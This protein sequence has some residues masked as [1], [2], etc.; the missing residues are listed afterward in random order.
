MNDAI[1]M[2]SW[3]T[4][5]DGVFFISITTII[6]GFLGLSVRYCLKSKCEHF[7]LC[8]GLIK[9]DR[10]VDLEVQEEMRALEMGVNDTDQPTQQQPINQQPTQPTN[11][12]Q[13]PRPKRR[14]SNNE[15]DELENIQIGDDI[16]IHWT[17]SGEELVTKFICYGKQGLE[18]D[19]NDE[20]INYNP[21]DDK[22]VLCFMVDIELLKSESMFY[23]FV[24]FF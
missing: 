16:A 3:M 17:P 10:R 1:K 12:H 13:Q 19:H 8:F 5:Y 11:Q 21:E 20:V 24:N 4:V 9:I 15:S 6:F 22:K 14:P 18:R 23:S 2:V 7:S